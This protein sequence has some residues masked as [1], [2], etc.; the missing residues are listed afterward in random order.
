MS[1]GYLVN[2]LIP[3]V[4]IQVYTMRF[5]LGVQKNTKYNIEYTKLFLKPASQIMFGTL[6]MMM[7]NMNSP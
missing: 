3:G 5:K 2:L 7:T 1:G 4:E 6:V